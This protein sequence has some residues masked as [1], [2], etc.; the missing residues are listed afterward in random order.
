MHRLTVV[1]GRL[2]LRQ[3]QNSHWLAVLHGRHAELLEL[4]PP[5]F[6]CQFETAKNPLPALVR[7]SRSHPGLIFLLEYERARCKGLAKAQAAVLFG[8]AKRATE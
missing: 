4:P 8:L 3:F 6:V 7:L 2:R 5:R 1:G